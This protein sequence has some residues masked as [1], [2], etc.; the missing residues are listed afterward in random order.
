M[1]RALLALL[2]C[3]CATSQVN[4]SQRSPGT[5]EDASE[6]Q[7]L[8]ARQ[9]S[10]DGRTSPSAESRPPDCEKVC[11]LV[12]NICAL[13]DRIC[14]IRD[15]HPNEPDFDRACLDARGRCARHT[16]PDASCGCT[17]PGGR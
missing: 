9:L 16:A 7:A 15:R 11:A 1:K 13:A 17:V 6:V 12:T 8:L 3:G 4:A 2:L 5:S 10:L 14:E